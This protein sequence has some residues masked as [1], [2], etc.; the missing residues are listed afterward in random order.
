M[1]F[2]GFTSRIP[3]K[4][5]TSISKVDYREGQFNFELE[6]KTGAKSTHTSEALLFAIG[7]V[8]NTDSLG[9]ENT[10]VELDDRGYMKTDDLMRTTAD[11]VYAMG[12][13][14]GLYFFT[15]SAS[16]EV[17]YLGRRLLEGEDV[18]IDYGPMPHGIFSSPQIGGVG[19]TE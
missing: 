6:A 15:D 10:S 1:F 19:S 7:R 8:P 2:K 17:G 4:L 12:D 3:V 18:P 13:V 11:G 9:L 5:S 16:F 14:I